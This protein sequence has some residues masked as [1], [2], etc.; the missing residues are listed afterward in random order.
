MFPSLVNCCTINW[1]VKW[2]EEAL[3]SVAQNSLKGLDTEEITNKLAE[4]CVI[5][6]KVKKNSI[7]F[8][9]R[10]HPLLTL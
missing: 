9:G 1:F 6:H 3:L 4:V 10:L 5:M 2:P 7:Q 8:K